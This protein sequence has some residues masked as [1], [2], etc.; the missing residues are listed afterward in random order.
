MVR[1]EAAN[2]GEGFIYEGGDGGMG[3][4]AK[5]VSG[6]RREIELRRDG[7]MEHARKDDENGEAPRVRAPSGLATVIQAVGRMNASFSSAEHGKDG[8]LAR[9]LTALSMAIWRGE[10][11]SQRARISTFL[12]RKTALRYAGTLDSVDV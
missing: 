3:Y 5:I 6:F 8:K 7:E 9:S 4:G 2:R 11:P 1:V 10:N 12:R